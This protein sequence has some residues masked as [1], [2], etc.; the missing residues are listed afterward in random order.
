MNEKK[1]EERNGPYKR[2]VKK[3]TKKNR[4]EENKGLKE[5]NELSCLQ[6]VKRFKR[7]KEKERN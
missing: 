1:E 6:N 5:K 7:N 3:Q 2:L 4:I